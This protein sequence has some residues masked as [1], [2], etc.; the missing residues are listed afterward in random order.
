[1]KLIHF[2][3]ESLKLNSSA[4]VLHESLFVRGAFIDPGAADAARGYRS[5]DEVGVRAY[6]RSHY[7]PYLRARFAE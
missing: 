7:R 6:Q 3:I 4:S 1:M 2:S 5:S